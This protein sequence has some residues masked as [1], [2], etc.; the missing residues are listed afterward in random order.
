MYLLSITFWLEQHVLPCFFKSHFHVDCPGC[1]FQRSGIALLKGD[2]ANSFIYYPALIPM[3]LYFGFL[4]LNSKYHFRNARSI[5]NAG[6]I[7][8]FVII[9][10]SYIF[11]LLNQN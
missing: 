5:I 2:I 8:I 3:L 10:T 6:C 11:K 7:M 1:G 4:A 9:G